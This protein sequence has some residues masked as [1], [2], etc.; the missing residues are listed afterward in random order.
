[1]NHQMTINISLNTAKLNALN[2]SLLEF[3]VWQHLED[4][5]DKTQLHKL[6]DIPTVPVAHL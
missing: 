2:I 5:W 3:Q 6:F 4:H 1:M